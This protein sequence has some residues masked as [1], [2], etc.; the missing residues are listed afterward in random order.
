MRIYINDQAGNFESLL[1]ELI[2][3]PTMMFDKTKLKV[4]A[5]PVFR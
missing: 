5:M 4:K 2:N 1:K 3:T